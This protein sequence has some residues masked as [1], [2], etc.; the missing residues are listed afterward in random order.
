[1]IRPRFKFCLFMTIA[2]VAGGCQTQQVRQSRQTVNTHTYKPAKKPARY[3]NAESLLNSEGYWDL[4][5]EKQEV[6]PIEQHMK[7][8]VQVDPGKVKSSGKYTK[9]G[10]PD[11]KTHFRTL[12]LASLE[13]VIPPKKPV[14]QPKK[15]MSAK[16][17][18]I[19]TNPKLKA[20]SS[21]K[22]ARKPARIVSNA[23]SA[24]GASIVK[25][26]RLGEHPGKTRFVLDLTGP[27]GFSYE[28]NNE[29]GY[30]LINLPGT[31]WEAN[32]K[33]VMQSHSLIKGYSVR[34]DSKGTKMLVALKKPGRMI[35]S[36]SLPPSGV[37]GHRIY[38]DIGDML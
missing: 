26:V 36:V 4:V 3:T 19:N 15:F 32:T 37:S 22:P 8:R 30:L 18:L 2:L 28:L 38:F 9:H 35:T 7:A 12:R 20:L 10:T 6:S 27:S 34:S 29:K 16:S 11:E 21:R 5:E 17:T 31:A 13:T 14:R 33:K 23:A 24:S 25:D 1:M